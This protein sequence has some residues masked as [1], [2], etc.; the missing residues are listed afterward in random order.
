MKCDFYLLEFEGQILS[1]SVFHGMW[2]VQEPGPSHSWVLQPPLTTSTRHHKRGT[3]ELPGGGAKAHTGE[4]PSAAQR[5]TLSYQET[6]SPSPGLKA[7]P[8][9]L[10]M[11]ASC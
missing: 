5:N 4:S 11:Q 1:T 3:T 10:C 8:K 9:N 2:K 6:S 7:E